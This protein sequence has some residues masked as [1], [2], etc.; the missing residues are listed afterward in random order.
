MGQHSQ[1]L[2]DCGNGETH[3][4]AVSESVMDIAPRATLY[5]S[6]PRSRYELSDAVDWMISEGVSVIN[7]SRVWSFDGPGDGTSPLS[8]SPLNSIDTAVDAGIVWVSAAGNQARGTWFKRGPDYTTVNSDDGDYKL[9]NFSGSN[10]INAGSYIGGTLE[11]RWEDEWGRAGTDLDLLVYKDG[12]DE[13]RLQGNDTQSGANGDLPYESVSGRGP[14]DIVIVHR[15]GPE[16]E[17]IQLVGWGQTRLERNSSGAGSI[18]NPAESGNP[19]MLAVGA[20]LWNDV[21]HIDDYSSQGPTPDGRVKPDV[22]AAHCGET[23]AWTGPFCGTSQAAPHVAGM[24]AL[25]RQRFPNYTPAQVVAYLKDNAEQRINSPDP[26]NTWGHG[27]FVL[28][29]VTQ[30]EQPT[31]TVPGTASITSVGPGPNALTVAWRAPLQTGGATITAYDLRHIRSDA[32]NKGDSNWTV[33][34]NVWTGSGALRVTRAGLRANTRYDVQVRAVNSAGEGAWSATSSRT[35]RAVLTPL[36]APGG[37]TATGNGQTFIDLSWSAPASDGGSSITGYR[38]EVSTNRSSWSDL[39]SNTGSSAT[40]YTHTGLTAGSTRHYRVSAINSA[41]TGSRS[42]VA[43]ASTDIASAPDLVVDRPTV[44]ASA[45]AAGARFTLNATVRNQGSGSSAFTT[46]RYYQSTDSTVTSGDAQVGTDSVSRLDAAESGGESVALTAPD[47]PG[48]YYYGACVDAVSDES[49]TAN[50]CSP[51]VAVTVGAAPAPDLVVDRP[52]VDASAP[53]AGARFILSAKVR[54]QGSGQSAFTT[55]RYYQSSDS[56][57]TSGDAQVGT[58]S[59]SRLDAAESGGESVALTAPDTPGAYYYGACVDAVSDESD[60]ANNCSPAVAVTVGA[61]PAPDLV[62]DRPTVDASAPAA[63]ARFILSAKV[64]NQGSGQ[65][66]FTTLRYYQSSDS[67]I[68]SG[69]A[70][71]GTDSVSRLDAAES[72]GE[73]VTLTAPDT[74]GTYY[75][76]ACVDSVSDESGTTNN[77]SVAVAVTVGAAPA[78]DLVVDRPTVSESAPAGGASFT[79]NASVRNQGSGAAAFTT[80]RYYQSTDSAITAGDTQVGTDSVSRLDTSE[81]GDDSVTLTAPSTPGTYYYGAC[82]DSVSDESDTTNNCSVAVAVAVGAAP[83]PDL[84]VDRPTVS[85]S[86]PEA[87]AR[88]TLSATVRNQGNGASVSTTLRYYQSTDPTIAS[89]D[90]E[91]GTDSVFRLNASSSGDESISLTAPS[92]AGT[93]YYGACVDAVSDESDAANNCSVAVAVT[94][95][96]ALVAPSNQRYIWQGSATVVSWDQVPNAGSYKVY[97]DD[98]FGSSCRLSGGSPSFCEEV[99]GNVSGTSYTHANPDNDRNYYWIAACNDAGCSVIDSGNPAQREGA[100]PAPDLVVD[101]PTVSENAPDAGVHFT[102]SAT[103]RNQGNGASA[104]STLRYYRSTDSAITTGDTEAGTDE[105]SRLNASSSGDE[106]ITLAAPDTP[107][108]YYLG[109]CVQAVSGE[110]D[111]TNNCSEAVSVT[112][113]S[114]AADETLPGVPRGL[115]ATADSQTEIDLSWTAPTDDGGA[116]ITGYKIEVST[117]G[118][119]WSDLVAN[120]NSTATTYPHTGLA[121]RDTRYYR[122]S[123]INSAGTGPASNTANST[124]DTQQ[125]TSSCTTGSAVPNPANNPGLVADCVTLLEARDTLA[126]TGTLNW[127]PSTPIRNWN[128]IA[129]GGTPQRVTNLELRVSSTVR[130]TGTI[131]PELGNL[132]NLEVLSIY[133]AS[134]SDDQLIGLTGTIPG[135]LGNLT[136][137][138]KLTLH[139]HG[140][141]GTIPAQLGSLTKLESLNLNFTQLNGRIPAQLG[142]LTS[143]RDLSLYD[144]Q[145]SGALPSELGSLTELESLNVNLNRLSGT[146]PAELSNLD[147]LETLAMSFN[148]LSGTIPAELSS[149]TNLQG[150]FLAH[151]QFTGCIPVGLSKVA[152]NDLLTLG[153]PDCGEATVPDAPTALTATVD[154]QTEIDLSWTAP[155]DDGGADIAGYKIEISTDRSN[156]SDLVAHTGSTTTSYSHTGLDSGSTWHYR[157]S[158]INSEGTGP[159]SNT[160]A[161]TTDAAPTPDLVVNTPTVND[162]SSTAGESFTLSATVRNQGDGAS[163]STTLRYYRSSDSTITTG[164]TEVGTDSVSGL[165]AGDSGDGSVT[166]TTPDTPGTYYYGACVDSVSGESDTTNNCSASVAVTVSAAPAPDLVVDT[167]TVSDSS[168][169]AGESFTLSATVRNQGDGPS[170]STTL[171][172]YRSSDST[173]ST[174]DTEVGTDSVSSLSA[175][176]NGDESISLTAPDTP[177]TYYYGACVDSVSEESDTTNNCS[178]SAAVTVGAAPAPDPS[179]TP[180]PTGEAVTGTITSCEGEQVAP[181]INSYR[182][183]ISGTVTASR[184]VENVRVEGTFNGSFVGIDVVGDMEAGEIASFSVTGYVSESVGSCGADVEWLE[185]N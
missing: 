150:L 132:T 59:V 147:N 39:V 149:L 58:D 113:E 21:D 135:L 32:P 7:H 108:T 123:A 131:P 109:A 142:S 91:V 62:V 33:N 112:V 14:V 139:Q 106:S 16:P 64:R 82:A 47:T 83:A 8:I 103:V 4:T 160:D 22:V 105:V 57:V 24:V 152:Q 119:S 79:L 124:T 43:E 50:N 148:Q 98:F 73:S 181:G 36:G 110:S 80:L 116:D 96:A 81:T 1:N 143:L 169:T 183:T 28:P 76:G 68:T 128:G 94:V 155:S 127:S 154:G 180:K 60:T 141:T 35:T 78:P 115:T 144:N 158:A 176:D 90:T 38:I 29:P 185:I 159:A 56:T 86:T 71:V 140:L 168:P 120:T 31:P 88:F 161:A 156:W 48:A 10:T 145:L 30:P 27:F 6:D 63:G 146:I 118:S 151:N 42:N 134:T 182:I 13:I 46:L 17:W 54:N 162:S 104:P 44:D 93:Y 167:P 65:S 75:Y 130:V 170:G 173:I 12:T 77:C 125:V 45:P 72:G 23:A 166:R 126:G 61:A 74:P 179:P 67:T 11:L 114:D 138:R 49:D 95:A 66:A 133:G 34:R 84:V 136:N 85:E 2:S 171:R 102:L 164:D 174:G 9:L 55:L 5:I 99:A 107:G 37:L 172:Y 19:G 129:V 92:T 175:G 52:T 111:T 51:A 69:D 97:H 70:Q 3:G 121:A 163:G 165:S 177:G 89:G 122:V 153:L 18:I 157:V 53:A 184:A 100:A 15:G 137:L 178:A 26:N 87:G 41:G 117:N 40:G 20:A 25:V 101:T